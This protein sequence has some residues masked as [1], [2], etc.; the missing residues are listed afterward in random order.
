V[1]SLPPYLTGDPALSRVP[2]PAGFS[3]HYPL[4]VAHI[5]FASVAI[6]TAV[7]QVWPG[8]RNRHPVMH[9]RTGR[10][11]VYAAVPAAACALVIGAATPFG[12]ILAVSNVLGRRCGCGSR[13]LATSRHEAGVSHRIGA[14]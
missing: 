3:L 4:L 2:A 14:R 13:S 8:L 7:A 5:T 9:R 10:V 12:P 6:T 1:Y 11:Y